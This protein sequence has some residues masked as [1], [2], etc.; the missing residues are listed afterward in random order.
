LETNAPADAPFVIG[1]LGADRFS[2]QFDRAVKN[3]K[4]GGRKVVL[5]RS[6]NITELAGSKILFVSDSESTR[7]TEILAD[8]ATQPVLTVSD[9]DGFAQ[10]GGMIGFYKDA[11]RVK[12]EINPRPASSSH[13]QVSAKL[14]QVGRIVSEK[15]NGG[16]S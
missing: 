3:E 6:N 9:I 16:G 12:F 7:V 8:V 4:V 14:L 15:S 10:T 2:E 5:K 11:G 13:L 1:I